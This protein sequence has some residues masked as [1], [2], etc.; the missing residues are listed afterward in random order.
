MSDFPA[1][2]G[3]FLFLIASLNFYSDLYFII[4]NILYFELDLTYIEFA[5]TKHSIYLYDVV[6]FVFTL[7]CFRYTERHIGSVQEEILSDQ[8]YTCKYCLR[9]NTSNQI[10]HFI[11]YI[12][13][14]FGFKISWF[15]WTL[16]SLKHCVFLR[17]AY[18]YWCFY[19]SHIHIL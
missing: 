6:H 14:N 1:E 16:T 18:L 9:L 11:L 5:L 19:Y 10:W 7:H 3:M 4:T 12:A 2:G 8:V 13:Y 17:Y 15:R